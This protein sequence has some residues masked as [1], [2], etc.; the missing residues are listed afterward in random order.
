MLVVVIVPL[1]FQAFG[2]QGADLLA[3][4]SLGVH[5]PVLLALAV[6]TAVLNLGVPV[7]TAFHVVRYVVVLTVTGPLYRWRFGAR[8]R[9]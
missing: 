6:A 8:P 9:A 7:V 5:P 4:A 1:A 3:N 2:L